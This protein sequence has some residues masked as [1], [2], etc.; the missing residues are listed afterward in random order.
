MAL[1]WIPGGPICA[2]FP[3]LS[4]A[5]RQSSAMFVQCPRQSGQKKE[6]GWAF[7]QHLIRNVH[8]ASLRISRTWTCRHAQRVGGGQGLCWIVEELQRVSR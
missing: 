4:G 6:V 1:R 7:T 5:V 8:V 3:V 2:S